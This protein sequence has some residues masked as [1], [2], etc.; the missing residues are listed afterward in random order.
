M[1][2]T[3][4]VYRARAVSATLGENSKG[5]EQV[6][7]QFRFLAAELV[8]QTITWY[9]TFTDKSADISIKALRA[10]GWQG[11]DLTE[12][13]GIDANDV[14]LV[15]ANETW[16]G[17]SRTKVKWVN[18]INALAMGTPLAQ[19]KAKAFAARMKGTILA[20]D[21]SNGTPKKARPV[22]PPEPPPHSDSDM[23]P[24]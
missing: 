20:F 22:T 16:E 6:A 10:C 21:K 18:P 12:L 23:P 9:G 4:G 13:L 3:D 7:I 15:V 11:N 2:M 8:G 1:E 19:D 14:D 17:K 24:V 5:N